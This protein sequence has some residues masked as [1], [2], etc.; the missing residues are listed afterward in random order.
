MMTKRSLLF[1]MFSCLQSWRWGKNFNFHNECFWIMRRILEIFA[2]NAYSNKIPF[3]LTA[4]LYY[5][6]DDDVNLIAQCDETKI[7]SFLGSQ[8]HWHFF[9][10]NRLPHNQVLFPHNFT[11]LSLLTHLI[12]PQRL[13][14]EQYF[15]HLEHYQ[16]HSPTQP[17]TFIVIHPHH[18]SCRPWDCDNSVCI[19]VTLNGNTFKEKAAP[20]HDE[21]VS[22]HLDK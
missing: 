18:R 15:P 2:F 22:L 6:D 1:K 3:H 20:S 19:V 7:Y 16:W 13:F 17:Q 8:S 21:V 4:S 12:H 5:Y 9:L 14:N 11:F 10:D